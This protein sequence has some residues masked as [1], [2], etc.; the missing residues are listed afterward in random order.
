MFT[1]RFA[2]IA[3]LVA[4]AVMVFSLA[5]AGTAEARMGGSFG[6]RGF[7]TYQS[8][9]AT[10]TSP[11]ATSPIQRSMTPNSGTSSPYG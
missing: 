10:T 2:K 8:A 4:A 9:P 6:S 5:A 11:F 1:S 3:S 7:R